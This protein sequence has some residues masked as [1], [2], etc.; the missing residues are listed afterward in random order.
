MK[1]LCGSGVNSIKYIEDY[2][3]DPAVDELSRI[4]GVTLMR[5]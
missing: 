4:T 2:N 1:L 3:N 5:I